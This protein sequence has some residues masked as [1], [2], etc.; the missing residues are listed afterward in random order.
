MAQDKQLVAVKKTQ[1]W[2]QLNAQIPTDL[3]KSI[4]KLATDKDMSISELVTEI[5]SH[6][7]AEV[8]K[9]VGA[10]ST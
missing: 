9:S 10:K 3:K 5:L 6:H 7:I 2:S 4:K 8:G 1:E